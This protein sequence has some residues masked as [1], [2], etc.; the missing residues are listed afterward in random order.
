MVFKS[1]YKTI[2][3]S[4]KFLAGCFVGSIQIIEIVLIL[5]YKIKYII[6][7]S[8]NHQNECNIH[9]NFYVFSKLA[10]LKLE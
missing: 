5:I 9:N 6:N 8:S 1:S 4:E 10:Y 7:I 3:I 2:K